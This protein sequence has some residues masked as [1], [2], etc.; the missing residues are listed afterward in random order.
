VHDIAAGIDFLHEQTYSLLHRNV[1]VSILADS[2]V[3]V[4][5]FWV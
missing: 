3:K 4:S 5:L 1:D 2:I